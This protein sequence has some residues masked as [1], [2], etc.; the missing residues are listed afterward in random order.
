MI[1][2]RLKDFHNPPPLL[3][4]EN[5]INQIRRASETYDG[6]KCYG[7]Y[8]DNTVRQ[9]L[10]AYSLGKDT[11]HETDSPKCYYCESQGE[12]MGKLQVEHFRP[13]DAVS[14]RDL[15]PGEIH[16]GYYWLGNEWTNH[17][18]SCPACN[19]SGAKGTRFPISGTRVSH[20][21]PVNEVNQLDR[22]HCI[23]DTTMLLDEQPVLLNPEIDSP[24]DHLTFDDLGQIH[25]KNNSERGR[26]TIEILDLWR[27]ALRAARQRIID[28][29]EEDLQELV[30]IQ[31]QRQYF[32]AEQLLDL[33]NG[34]CRK[35][36]SRKKKDV[37]YTLWGI[38]INENFERIFV[39]KVPEPYK[40]LL[41]NAYQTATQR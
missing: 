23:L 17:L 26:Q 24:E 34:I 16:N 22:T 40:D 27:D 37:A 30:I 28:E 21:S 18:L 14:K 38:Y 8:R 35:I 9:L 12:E 33:F 20:H 25:P 3:I 29:F 39:E 4:D 2:I 5:S 31:E 36:H 11:Y 41:R 6:K 32:Q 1:S 15:Q 7:I 13:K 19:G 10:V